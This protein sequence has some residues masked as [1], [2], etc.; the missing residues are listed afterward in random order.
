MFKVI[1]LNLS[2]METKKNKHADLNRYRN[3]ILS[4]GLLISLSLII[5]AFEWKSYDDGI[6][7]IG[8]PTSDF[9]EDPIIPPTQILPPSP[10][11]KPIPI[12]VEVPNDQEIIDDLPNIDIVIDDG[13]L[14]ELRLPIPPP[15]EVDLYDEPVLIA[16]VSAEP[17]DGFA[18]FYK[19]IANRMKYPAQARRMQI[20]G[21]VFVEFVINRDGSITEIKV[22]KGIGGEC[23]EEAV[24]VLKSSPRW[25]PAKQRGVPV[26]QRMVLPITFKLG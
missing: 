11:A 19:D 14:P 21:R 26:R 10:P 13:P 12:V 6:D 4:F 9:I 17:E 22:I 16:E 24:R 7:I 23:D 20:E 5:T 2:T 8:C 1:H 25:K 18:L 15:I 3:L